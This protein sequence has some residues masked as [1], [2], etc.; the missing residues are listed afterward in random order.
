M[1]S[2]PADRLSLLPPYLFAEI[3]R[4]KREAIAGGRD[5]IDFGVGDPDLPTPGF[6]VDRMAAAIRDPVNHKYAIGTGMAE[7]RQAAARFL[8]RRFGVTVDAASEVLAL[9]GSKEGIG[10]LPIA[11][12]N[13]GDLV[14]VP[15]PG[16]PVY[17]SGTV[18]AGGSYHTMP[19][20]EQNGWLPDLNAIPREVRQRAKLMWLNYPN[21]PTGAVASLSFFEKA[22]DFAREHHI[23]IAQDAPY[24]ELYFGDPPPSILQ[25]E[26]AKDVA[27]EFHSLSKTFNMTGWRIAFAAGHREVLSALARVKS[28]L[29]SG[30]F[31]AVQWAGVAALDG[32]DRPE[33]RERLGIYRS[34]RDVLVAGLRDAGWP[35]KEP[36]ATF[37]L[38]AKC[39]N[40][41]DSMT[42]ATRALDEADVVVIPGAGLGEAGEGYVRFALTLSEERTRE[43]VERLARL[44]W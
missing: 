7:Y 9:L 21:N 4:R 34:R 6:I 23:L 39:P 20:R 41:T 3:D 10:H 18:F 32:F 8:E 35:V 17:V 11:V 29:D 42:V 25:I 2:P 30:V 28:N 5:V 14:L 22:V 43:A 24:C 27:I 31:Q 26:G 38:W 37:Y 15:E 13:P 12:I 1:K 16:Y 40:G 44:H 33:V 36:E 19:L